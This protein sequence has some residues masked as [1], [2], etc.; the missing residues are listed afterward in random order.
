MGLLA[1]ASARS[2]GLT[3]AAVALSMSWPG[4]VILAE[5]DPDGG[6]IAA[7]RA[8]NPDPGLKTLAAAGR[9]YLSPGLVTSNVQQLPGGLAVL[10]GPASPDRCVAAL[11]ALNPAGLG[12]TL[13]AIPGV[14]VIA[15]CGRIDSNS[16]ALPVVRQANAVVFVVRPTL[17]DIVGLRGRLETLDLPPATPAGIAVVNFGPH[18]VDDV[19]AAFTVPVLGTLEWD[20]RAASALNEGRR[21]LGRSKLLQSA[22]S[23]AAAL[24]L[25]LGADRDQSSHLDVA[26]PVLAGTANGGSRED[27]RWHGPGDGPSQSIPSPAWAAPGGTPAGPMTAGSGAEL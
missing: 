19:A 11:T 14:D 27:G 6:T 1:V 16:P 25:Q 2:P 8:A 22:E 13:R 4:K 9:H 17:V 18:D 26:E 3:T 7:S 12:E 23:L 10:M 21:V 5:L 15:D 20:P 24:S